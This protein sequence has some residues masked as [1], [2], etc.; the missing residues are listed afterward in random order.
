MHMAQLRVLRGAQDSPSGESNRTAVDK[1]L[2]R[3]HV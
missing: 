1:Q 2:M 3:P